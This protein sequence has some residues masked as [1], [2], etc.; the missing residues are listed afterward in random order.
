MCRLGFKISLLHLELLR[1]LADVVITVLIH[2]LLL[3]ILAWLIPHCSVVHLVE[4]V[5]ASLLF[6]LVPL[7]F[8]GVNLLLLCVKSLRR[9][10]AC[11]G[12]LGADVLGLVAD[13]V[14][15]WAVGLALVV[16]HFVWVEAV[17]G[18]LVA[19]NACMSSFW[20]SWR[21]LGYMV[22]SDEV[23]AVPN[24]WVVSRWLW[25]VVLLNFPHLVDSMLVLDKVLG[26]RVD[27]VGVK[28]SRTKAIHGLKHFPLCFG[29]V[30]LVLIHLAVYFSSVTISSHLM[31]NYTSVSFD[32]NCLCGLVGSPVHVF[33]M[34]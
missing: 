24:D 1:A 20:M 32:L 6:L 2:Q 11:D 23:G 17:C 18:L 16:L 3:K 14:E 15:L 21:L 10:W 12:L 30:K 5:V 27:P 13:L 7:L 29:H 9:W 31:F 28:A 26:R 4:T 25:N 19:S 8:L 33:G 34:L 22:Y